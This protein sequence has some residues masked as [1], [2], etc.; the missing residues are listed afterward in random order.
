MQLDDSEHPDGHI[1]VALHTGP[2]PSVTPTVPAASYC[3]GSYPATWERRSAVED[4]ARWFGVPPALVS[5]DDRDE[6]GKT[7]PRPSLLRRLWRWVWFRG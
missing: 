5:L 4:V 1:R 6:Q 2:P 3:S 7:A